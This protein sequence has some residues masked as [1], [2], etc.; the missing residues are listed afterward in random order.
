M[1]RV[2]LCIDGERHTQ[3]AVR[4]ALALAKGLG[5]E[6]TAL[7]VI[8]GFLLE[9]RISHELY[10]VGRNEYR[11]YVRKEL[12]KEARR[13]VREF[14]ELAR[15]AGVRFRT[16]LRFGHP[17]E[18]VVAEA[19]EGEYDLV[20]LGGKRRRGLWELK[21]RNLPLKVFRKLTLPVMVVR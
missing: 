4:Y 5:A 15:S 1:H 6:L 10:A 16:K 13:I 19:E 11:A 21:S 9:K 14:E 2:L 17:V 20:I 18:E 8:D 7:H 3:R 12:E